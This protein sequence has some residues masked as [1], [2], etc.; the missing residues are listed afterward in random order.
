MSEWSV[1]IPGEPVAR[2]EKVGR[3]GGFGR[4]ID[5]PQVRDYKAYARAHIAACRPDVLMDGPLTL[6]LT[7]YVTKPKSASKKRIWPDRKPD[8]SNILKCAED[9]L[10]SIV[11]VD[12]ARIVRH[13]NAK[14]YADEQ[15]PPG[16][17]IR[18]FTMEVLGEDCWE[19]AGKVCAI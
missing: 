12:D 16:L 8:L 11:I 7:A 6:E 19:R 17:K 3:I 9:C 13:I 5:K 10:S 18:V 4:I 15:N 2:A 14:H 1:F